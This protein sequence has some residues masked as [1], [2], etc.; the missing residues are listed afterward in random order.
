MA[1]EVPRSEVELGLQM[2]A[3]ASATATPDPSC[4]CDL[5]HSSWQLCILNPLGRPGMNPHPHGYQLGSL[6]LSHNGNFQQAFQFKEKP[7]PDLVLGTPPPPK[8]Q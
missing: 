4:L 1:Y 6:P 3:Y 7:D 2:L 5:H 8:G